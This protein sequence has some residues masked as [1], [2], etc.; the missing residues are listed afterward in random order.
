MNKQNPSQR[1]CQDSESEIECPW[2]SMKAERHV[3]ESLL[4]YQQLTVKTNQ[5]PAPLLPKCSSAGRNEEVKTVSCKCSADYVTEMITE[6]N[7]Y[8]HEKCF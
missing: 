6:D 1:G 3:A 7:D 4:S 8:L 5:E 2:Q